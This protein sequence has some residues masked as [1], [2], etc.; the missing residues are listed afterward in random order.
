MCLTLVWGVLTSTGWVSRL[1][2]REALRGAHQ[3]LATLTLAFAFVHGVTLLMLDSGAW[4]FAEVVVP[5]TESLR[6]TFGTLAFEGMLAASI[7]V[8]L[9][10]WMSYWRWMWIHRLAYPA[11]V[12]GVVHAFFG[13][14]AAGSLATVWLGG[15]TLLVPAVTVMLLRFV[16]ARTLSAAGLVEDA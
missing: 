4:G 10:R 16:P 9:K 2:G 11:F 13:A 5:F 8:A 6:Y 15:I 7:A 14:L 1:T 3:T 12:L